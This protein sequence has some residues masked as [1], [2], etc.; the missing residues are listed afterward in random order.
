[1]FA[2]QLF[3]S[4]AAMN[5]L[6]SSMAWCASKP[7]KWSILATLAFAVLWPFVNGILEGTVLLRISS[8]H[9]ITVSDLLSVLA[10]AIALVQTRR[11]LRS[12]RL[13]QSATERGNITEN[14]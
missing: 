4:I 6:F 10:V 2:E 12:R 9:G 3:Y 13:S 8:T 7:N 1:M 14:P 11:I 5:A